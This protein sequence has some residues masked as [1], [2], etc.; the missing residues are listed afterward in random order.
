MLGGGEPGHSEALPAGEWLVGPWRPRGPGR[1][2]WKGEVPLADLGGPVWAAV[3]GGWLCL[4]LTWSH[5]SPQDSE[6]LTFNLSRHRSWWR[7]HGPGCVRKE[8]AAGLG[9]PG[10]Q[11]PVPGISCA[12]EHS[13]VEALH[14]ALQILAAVSSGRERARRR[15]SFCRGTGLEPFLPKAGSRPPPGQGPLLTHPCPG[16]KEPYHGSPPMWPG[17]PE[18]QCPALESGLRTTVNPRVSVRLN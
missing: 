3:G 10:G 7:E 12:L 13:Y 11:A 4:V 17:P 8:P 9:P 1:G 6:L 18:P 16:A 5:P 2:R 14:S 15:G